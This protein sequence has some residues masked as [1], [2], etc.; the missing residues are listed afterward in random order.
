MA[1]KKYPRSAALHFNTTRRMYIV[2]LGNFRRSERSMANEQ[3][4]V[5]DYSRPPISECAPG[6]AYRR[7]SS[8]PLANPSW[9]PT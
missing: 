5:I 1:G 9:C 4:N 6:K 8:C 7:A 3:R 2:N